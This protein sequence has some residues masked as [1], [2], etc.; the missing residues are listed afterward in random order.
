MTDLTAPFPRKSCRWQARVLATAGDDAAELQ[1]ERPRR[2]VAKKQVDVSHLL[3]ERVE[4]G[5]A[6]GG[7]WYLDSPPLTECELCAASAARTR[8]R[9]PPRTR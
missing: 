1:R 9:Q 4:A 3:G 2:L 7:E 8:A 5:V 6:E